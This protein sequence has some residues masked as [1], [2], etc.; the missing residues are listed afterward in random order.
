[1]DL[2][3]LRIGYG[4]LSDDCRIGGDLRRFGY[5]AK[6]RNFNFEIADPSETYDLVFLTQRADISVWSQYQ[7]GNC[8]IIYD[9]VDSY[10]NVPKWNIKG[11]LRGSAKYIT[12]QSRY[13]RLNHWKAL[14]DMCLRSD[15]VACST[16]EQQISIQPFCKNAHVILDFHFMLMS[17]FK[18]DYSVG[19][20]FNFV[21]EGMA[22]NLKFAFEIKEVLHALSSKYKIAFHVVTD[23]NYGKYMGKYFVKPT[24]PL[25]KKIFD[26]S[27][28]HE[29]KGK[30][31]ASIMSSF[32]M[33]LV[34][35]PL[36]NPF[37]LDSSLAIG[38]PINKLLLLWRMGLP[39]VVSKTPAYQRV[40]DECG[41][42]M[43]CRTQ[44][45]W[46]NTLE[47]YINDEAARKEAGQK[48]KAFVEKNYSEEI[49][50]SK[51]DALF[52]SVL[53]NKD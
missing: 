37:E 19:D 16:E 8:K 51:W 46:F 40:M 25:A 48:G 50:L 44:D 17:C 2:S 4:S 26:H 35:I 12:G 11:V 14:E 36:N 29:L 39:T 22:G 27:Y 20:T 18:A 3:S 6:K 49:L 10:L 1:M 53:Q 52:S 7:K 45:E 21:W 15:A 30:T 23:L 32:D 31:Y 13:L 9:F 42:A 33:A 41:L 28:I 5:Y 38:K 43:T 47:K 24:L 34:P